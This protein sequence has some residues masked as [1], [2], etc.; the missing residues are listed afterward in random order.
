MSKFPDCSRMGKIIDKNT[1][2][3][4]SNRI[5]HPKEGFADFKTCQMCPYKNQEDDPELP[6]YSEQRHPDSQQKLP[7]I[8]K[9]AG[10]FVKAVAGHVK[11]GAKKVT[12]EE[13]EE[14]LKAC[15]DCVFMKNNRCTHMNC[16]CVL[17]RKARWRSED[18]PIERWPKLDD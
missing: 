11:D 12:Q 16:G 18:C 3:C 4:F 13:L 17:A 7:S 15:N 8:G 2:E 5:I 1:C 10:N 9:M 6:S 14:R